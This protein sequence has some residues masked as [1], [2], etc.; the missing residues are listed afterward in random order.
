MN[1]L[2]LL[3]RE[4]GEEQ[5]QGALA[6]RLVHVDFPH[7]DGGTVAFPRNL[8]LPLMGAEQEQEQLG[9]I[10][11]QG[12]AMPEGSPTRGAS[13]VANTIQSAFDIAIDHYVVIDLDQLAGLI[14]DF[15]G[16][17]V[18]I[19]LP[20]DASGIGLPNFQPGMMHMGGDMA[21]SLIHI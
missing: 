9:E 11:R 20:Y 4:K 15:G 5:P 18:E 14:D 1:V 12:Q 13:L 10:F 2:V 3:I 16:V 19:H 17:D 8:V 7:T 21:L 6:M